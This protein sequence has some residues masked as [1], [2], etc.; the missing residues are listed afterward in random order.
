MFQHL[1]NDWKTDVTVIRG[2]GLDDNGDPVS[3]SE[4]AL[5]GCLLAPES[6]EDPLDRSQIVTGNAVLYCPPGSEEVLSTDRIR[7]PTSSAMPG[8]WSVDGT[9]IRW[10]FGVQVRLTKGGGYR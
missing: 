4:F 3:S 2:G 9:P 1:P 10:P 5:S 8:E 7:T 6:R